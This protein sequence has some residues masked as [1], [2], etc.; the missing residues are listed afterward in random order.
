[1]T[2]DD[3]TRAD[4]MAF[5]DEGLARGLGP[6]DIIATIN[7]DPALYKEVSTALLKDFILDYLKR[8][9]DK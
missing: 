2:D 1:M 6:E 4:A 8:C 5:I 9:E 7:A 3:K